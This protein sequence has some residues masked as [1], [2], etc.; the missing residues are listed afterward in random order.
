LRLSHEECKSQKNGVTDSLTFL[1]K[2]LLAS[3][4]DAEILGMMLCLEIPA[5]ENIE[6]IFTALAYTKRLEQ[7]L[8]ETKF[9]K[10][11]RQIEIEH[12]RL[13]VA[14]FLRFCRTEKEREEFV[15]GCD[16]GLNFWSL[17]WSSVSEIIGTERGETHA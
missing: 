14:N 16:Q 6:T 3:S 8:A 2:A 13:S 12:I 4:S 1:R 5:C 17:F 11:H 10:F 15:R 7:D 9:F